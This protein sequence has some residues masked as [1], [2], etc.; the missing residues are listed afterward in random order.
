MLLAHVF[1]DVVAWLHFYDLDAVMLT[2]A[3][4]SELARSAASKIRIF[5]FSGFRFDL[6]DT[7]VVVYSASGPTV[8]DFHSKAELVE[9]VPAALRNCILGS[10]DLSFKDSSNAI[11]KVAHTIVIKGTLYLDAGIFANAT[12]LVEFAFSFRSVQVSS[13]DRQNSFCRFCP[14]CV[15]LRRK[16]DVAN[17]LCDSTRKS[18][19]AR[20]LHRF[21]PKKSNFLPP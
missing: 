17:S 19:V 13:S 8:L 14:K 6:Y 18:K 16:K 12:A 11:I 21:A 20:K 15:Q 7:D 3:R 4:C 2:E 9:F 1:A 5:D 10:M